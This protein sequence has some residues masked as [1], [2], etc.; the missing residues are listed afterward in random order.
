MKK[1]AEKAVFVSGYGC[2]ECGHFLYVFGWSHR[3]A[4]AVTGTG[5]QNQ[6]LLGPAGIKIDPAHAAGHIIIRDA[7][8]AVAAGVDIAGIAQI[9]RVT[10]IARMR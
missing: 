6:L 1:T 5:D 7:V 3:I 8:A 10:T 4:Q 2:K 9:E